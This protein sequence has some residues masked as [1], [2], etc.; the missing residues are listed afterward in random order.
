[1]QFGKP[2]SKRLPPCDV[3]GQD[4]GDIREGDFGVLCQRC[5]DRA[6]Y[7]AAFRFAGKAD[8]DVAPPAPRPARPMR[9]MV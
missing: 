8:P 9:R 6:I 7:V 4:Y 2:A 3:C 1:M 5:I